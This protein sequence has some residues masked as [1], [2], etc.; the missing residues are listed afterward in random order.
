MFIQVS[1]FRWSEHFISIGLNI[2]SLH[3]Q[4][5]TLFSLRILLY[6]KYDSTQNLLSVSRNAHILRKHECLFS[7]I[8]EHFIQCHRMLLLLSKCSLT[9][10][11]WRLNCTDTFV[12][13]LGSPGYTTL[14]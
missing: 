9:A 3:S 2:L 7:H 1:R 12:M 10:L 4:K 6:P 13:C 11:W 14:G 8:T 5:Q